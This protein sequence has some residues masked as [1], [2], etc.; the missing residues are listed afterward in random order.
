MYLDVNGNY[1]AFEEIMNYY[2]LDFKVYYI[3][4]IIVLINALK[5]IIDFVTIK[6]GK[7]PKCY[8]SPIDLVV[9]IL[10]GIGLAYGLFF[11]G[12]LSDIS[13]KYSEVWGSK[14]FFLC[15]ISFILF[16]IQVIFTLKVR[17]SKNKL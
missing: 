6:K 11:Q 2:H 16:I 10:A 8:S 13:S 12:V 17:N 4:A 9:S 5:V 14:I 3:L 15:L 1:S 7:V